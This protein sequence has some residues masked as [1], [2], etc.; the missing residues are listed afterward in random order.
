MSA[1][2]S[3]AERADQ[4]FFL[5]AG[6]VADEATSQRGFR[7]ATTE[8]LLESRKYARFHAALECLFSGNPIVGDGQVVDLSMAEGRFKATQSSSE[9]R[10]WISAPI[11]LIRIHR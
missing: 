1:G 7:W 2:S 10:R 4:N 3:H 11:H 9:G 5:C 6:P 8:G